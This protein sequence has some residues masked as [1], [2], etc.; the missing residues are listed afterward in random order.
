[1]HPDT[2]GL[3]IP[4]FTTHQNTR[5]AARA[6]W[7]KPQVEPTITALAPAPTAPDPYAFDHEDHPQPSPLP[8]IEP[9][10]IVLPRTGR[11]WRP[12]LATNATP[13]D[14]SPERV[15]R[16]GVARAVR[17][18]RDER[19]LDADQLAADADIPLWQ[20]T[21]IEEGRLSPIPSLLLLSLLACSAWR[22]VSCCAASRSPKE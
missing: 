21:A 15:F 14:A 1:M 16:A 6:R 3:P 9:E 4:K 8:A 17:E 12:R 2:G 18:L 5:T 19:Y 20:L 10:P 13:P 22:P 7:R 11:C